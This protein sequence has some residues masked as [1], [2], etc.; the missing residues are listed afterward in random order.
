VEEEKKKKC[1]RGIRVSRSYATV[2]E[3]EEGSQKPYAKE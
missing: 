2:F 3:E 1:G